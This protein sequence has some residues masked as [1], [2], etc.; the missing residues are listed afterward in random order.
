MAKLEIDGFTI[1]QDGNDPAALDAMIK[2]AKTVIKKRQETERQAEV[3]KATARL[4]AQAAYGRLSHLMMQDRGDSEPNGAFFPSDFGFCTNEDGFEVVVNDKKTVKIESLTFGH[5]KTS[6]NNETVFVNNVLKTGLLSFPAD[7]YKV[8]A[9]LMEISGNMLAI[10]TVNKLNLSI[11]WV[12]VG[13]CNGQAEFLNLAD[14]FNMTLEQ[15]YQQHLQQRQ[16]EKNR[17][18]E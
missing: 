10:R 15:R 18:A 13:A 1:I 5:L 12:A 16:A 7:E 9:C 11:Y 14:Y 17:S 6:K 3:D 2:R 4:Y 8:D